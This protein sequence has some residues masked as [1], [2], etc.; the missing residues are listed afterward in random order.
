MGLSDAQMQSAYI[1]VGMTIV[2]FIAELVVASL[3]ANVTLGIMRR[4][5][6]VPANPP[7]VT[8]VVYAQA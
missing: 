4:A 3:L 2:F 6:L 7:V 5:Q 8:T 1:T